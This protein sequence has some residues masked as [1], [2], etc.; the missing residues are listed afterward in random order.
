[1]V[2][3]WSAVAGLEMDTLVLVEKEVVVA[4]LGML[5]AVEVGV[6]LEMT[7]GVVGMAIQFS[8]SSKWLDRVCTMNSCK[9]RSTCRQLRV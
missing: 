8:V 6:E 1:M 5:V 7:A 9:L 2:E 4:G 3:L